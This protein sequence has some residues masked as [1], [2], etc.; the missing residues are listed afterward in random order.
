[1][2]DI[3]DGTLVVV[4]LRE[5]RFFREGTCVGYIFDNF[6]GGRFDK[7]LKKVFGDFYLSQYKGGNDGVR[8]REKRVKSI[9][10]HDNCLMG[11][12]KKDST[13]EIPK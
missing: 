2:G 11:D 3:K 5:T 12:I 4:T 10:I 1:M 7:L 8:I 6:N 9:D 13:E